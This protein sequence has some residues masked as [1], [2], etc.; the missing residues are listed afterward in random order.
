MKLFKELES[1]VLELWN[2]YGDKAM[3]VVNE[4]EAFVNNYDD[5]QR[6]FPDVNQLSITVASSLAF[7]YGSDAG[8]VMKSE[9]MKESQPLF[10]HTIM[11]LLVQR[12]LNEASGQINIE[13]ANLR[14]SRLMIVA[15]E[16]A[17]NESMPEASRDFGRPHRMGGFLFVKGDVPRGFVIAPDKGTSIEVFRDNHKELYEFYKL[18]GLEVLA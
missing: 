12:E 7:I 14:A 6:P 5:P 13:Q 4:C 1:Q 18:K 11:K 16:K 8:E 9:L 10:E 17:A 2:R 15:D 3:T